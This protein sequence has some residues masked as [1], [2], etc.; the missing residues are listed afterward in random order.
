MD[1]IPLQEKSKSRASGLNLCET[2]EVC[3]AINASDYAGQLV[4]AVAI[5]VMEVPKDC[6]SSPVAMPKSP[7]VV[8]TGEDKED[9]VENL[10]IMMRRILSPEPTEKPK[11]EL[12]PEA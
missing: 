11:I 12:V 3:H 5:T 7:S 2:I 6:P 1:N 9:L 4:A 10:V 8:I